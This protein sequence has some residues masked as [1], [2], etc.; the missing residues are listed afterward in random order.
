M[1]WA[2]STEERR[3]GRRRGR[4][5]GGREKDRRGERERLGTGR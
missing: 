2:V 3:G 5:R 1:N 4:E